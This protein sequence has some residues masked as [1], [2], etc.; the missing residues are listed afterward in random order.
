MNLLGKT[1]QLNKKKNCMLHFGPGPNWTQ[2]SSD[3]V[4][5]DVDP[6]RADIVMDFNKFERLPLEDESVSC[7][8]GSHIFEHIDIFHAP[9][10]FRE[11]CRVLIQKGYFRIVLP[12]VRRSIEEYVRGNKEF[13][14]FK[15]RVES[16]RTLLGV[17]EVSIFEALKGDFISPSGQ[18]DILGNYSLAH[19]NAWDFESLR[20]ELSRAGFDFEKV[21]LKQFRVSDCEYFSFEGTYPSEANESYR[22]IY[23]E[24][25]K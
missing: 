11:C 13:P 23:V 15:R 7:I 3:W 16:L 8:Y 21:R 19:Q 14:L 9:L 24:A 2:P 17:N 18:P 20:L 4:S 12:D 6:S 5:V 25:E 1:L 10:V 22:S